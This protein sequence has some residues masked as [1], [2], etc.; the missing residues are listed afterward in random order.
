[1]QRARVQIG[2]PPATM[3]EMTV[4]AFPGD[5]GGQHA[6][7][8]RW[9]RQVGLGPVSEEALPEFISPLTVAG[10]ESWQVDFTG[11]APLVEE[12]PRMIVSVVPFNGQTWFFKLTGPASA[13]EGALP[14]YQAFLQQLHLDHP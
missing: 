7:V 6:N 14:A 8:N 2:H 11:P 13:V 10:L 1:M 12:P 4:S 5:V 3:S 9:R